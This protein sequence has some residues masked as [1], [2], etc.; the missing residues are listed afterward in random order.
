MRDLE[1]AADRIVSFG[2]EPHRRSRAEWLSRAAL[3]IMTALFVTLL[4]G[5]DIPSYAEEPKT[6]GVYL[7]ADAYKQ[8]NLAFTGTCKS[9]DH[10]LELHDLLNK[11]YIDVTHE[12]QKRR[13][14]KSELFGFRACNGRDYR[15]DTNLEYQIFE[16]RELY[17]YGHIAHVRHGRGSR[18]VTYYYF[19]MGSDGP[20]LGLTVENLKRVSPGN[21][22]FHALLDENF[23]PRQRVEEYDDYQKMFKV[24]RL[25]IAS[26]E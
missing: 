20:L 8:G 7:T 18:S 14:A 19:S 1:N 5:V 21:E 25:L 17:I 9:E 13:Y 2:T 24:S 10:K 23:G 12:S 16:S 6:S 26:L 11:S 3:L 4:F 15:F 22:N